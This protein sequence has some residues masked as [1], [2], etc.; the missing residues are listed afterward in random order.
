M[1]HASSAVPHAS[2]L[3]CCPAVK[4]P[5]L[6]VDK[7]WNVK[8]AGEGLL[9]LHP[10]ATCVCLQRGSA[11]SSFYCVFVLLLS[12]LPPQAPPLLPS[13]LLP[14]LPLLLMACKL[15]LKLRSST[16]CPSQTSTCPSC[17]RAHGLRA[18]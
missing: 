9:L 18:A 15:C 5:N 12:L 16:L 11:V 13:L 14:Q 7:D 1:H 10:F 4:S 8:V 3:P 6:L 17:S 2:V